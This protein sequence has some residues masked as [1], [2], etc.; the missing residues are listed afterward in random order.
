MMEFDK[1]FLKS[2]T[3]LYAEDD[4]HARES[5]SNVL[6]TIFKK[7]YI[8]KDGRQGVEYFKKFHDRIDVII[9]DINMPHMNGIEFLK[10]IREIS[11]DVPF[12][13]TTAH[14]ESE[15]L[16]EAVKYG[17][18]Y[19]AHK[20]VN[21]KEIV[22]K[23]QE[24]C[25]LNFQRKKAE[26]NYKEAQ[27]YLSLI[28]QIALI[29]KTDLLG[30]IIYV[31]EL[32]CMV[33]GYEKDELIGQPHS[34]VRHPDTSSETFEELWD[35]IRDGRVWKGKLKNQDKDGE[36]YY[37]N[38]NIFPIYD[39]MDEDI[40]EFMAISFLTTDEE[41]EKREYKAQIRQMVLSHKKIETEL[42][43]KVAELEK[44]LYD[45]ENIDLLYANAQKA[46]E[47]N[48]KLIKQLRFY[49]DQLKEL[50]SE[51]ENVQQVSKDRFLAVM[52]KN[53][54]L[55]YQNGVMKKKLENLEIVVES[56]SRE[57][58]KLNTQVDQQAEI[59]LNLKDV[60]KHREEQL[61][62]LQKHKF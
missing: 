41:N 6:G 9:S 49:E 45:C 22:L 19:Y 15:Y 25:E 14:Q 43:K 51:K 34:I 26:H 17:V 52:K 48:K 18:F 11:K 42:R 13:F 44:K 8:A 10:N 5:M 28:N 39:D 60:I 1:K 30:D 24:A 36:P 62:K 61:A 40:I 2:L 35:T 37:V 27:F 33:S 3:V 47:Q 29:S 56:Q 57:I 16:M 50:K 55:K 21:I 31:N 23:V 12:I 53:K 59:I 20:P 4:E 54:D 32:F 7:A 58:Y 46:T 38:V